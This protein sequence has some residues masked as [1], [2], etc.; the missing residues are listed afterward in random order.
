M[1]YFFFFE[2]RAVGGSVTDHPGL[3]LFQKQSEF[4]V[5]RNSYLIRNLKLKRKKKSGNGEN[6]R[7]PLRWVALWWRILKKQLTA[8]ESNKFL[9][10]E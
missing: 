4:S 5:G 7:N 10:S 9:V 2:A 3:Y 1:K 8:F 6:K